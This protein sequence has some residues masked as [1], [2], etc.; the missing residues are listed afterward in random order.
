LFGAAAA[1][2]CRDANRLVKKTEAL[3]IRIKVEYDKYNRTFKLLDREFGSALEDGGL[4]ELEVPVSVPDLAED[5][6]F[7]LIGAPLAHA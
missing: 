7:A 4:Y 3:M 2:G 6:G 1:F 5:E